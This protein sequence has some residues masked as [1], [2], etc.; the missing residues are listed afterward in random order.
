MYIHKKLNGTMWIA[1]SVG[2]CLILGLM[3]CSISD[4]FNRDQDAIAV[5]SFDY[6]FELDSVAAL[7]ID[8]IN[9]NMEIIGTDGD[10][11]HIWGDRLVRSDTQADADAHLDQLQVNVR[12]GDSALLVETEQPEESQ[13]RSYEVDYHVRLP[14]SLAVAAHLVNGDIG[15]DE[16]INEVEMKLVNGDIDCQNIEGSCSGSVVNGE[17]NCEMIVSDQEQCSLSTVNGDVTLEIYK[18]SSAELRAQVTNGS[19]SVE[20]LQ[21][22]NQQISKTT[23]YGVIGDGLGMIQLQT[24]NGDIEVKGK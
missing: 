2:L 13:G 19:I 11:I 4:P 24:V 7:E 15:V 20:G 8:G 3:S 16:I 6:R 12:K 10:S 9:G 17:I 14:R 23:F 1:I 21:V 5:E 22:T 18:T